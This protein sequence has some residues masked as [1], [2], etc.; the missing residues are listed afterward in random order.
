MAKNRFVMYTE[1]IDQIGMLTDEEAGQLLKAVLEYAKDGEVPNIENRM[2][3]L[4]FSFIMAQMDRDN[5]KYE[6]A[7]ERKKEA[8]RQGGLAKASKSKQNL[9]EPSKD[10]A[11]VSRG[12]QNLDDNVDVDVYVDDYEKENV[13]KKKPA[14]HKYGQYDNVLLTDD[15]LENLKKEFPTDYQERIDTLSAYMRSTGKAYKDHLATIR[16]WARRE[17]RAKPVAKQ[18]AFDRMER[19]QYDFEAI[20]KQLLGR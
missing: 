11:D 3:G 19:Q 15:D 13:K 17:T 1:Y 9:A 16:N 8:G 12:K 4:T 5:E 20:E 2:V 18:T 7:I 10:L 14:R 6:A